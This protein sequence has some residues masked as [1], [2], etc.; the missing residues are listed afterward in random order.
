MIFVSLYY[1]PIRKSF[2]TIW[3]GKGHEDLDILKPIPVTKA[4]EKLGLLIIS[5]LVASSAYGVA[6]AMSRQWPDLSSGKVKHFV[7]MLREICRRTDDTGCHP[8][9]SSISFT[10][11]ML[12]VDVRQKDS[13]SWLLIEEKDTLDDDKDLKSILLHLKMSFTNS[14]GFSGRE[15]FRKQW[16]D[17][18]EF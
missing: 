8:A 1:G 14:I 9:R 16:N 3:A 13:R 11:T 17:I 2:E 10:E 4:F 12:K 6:R 15:D 7:E 5:G 18:L